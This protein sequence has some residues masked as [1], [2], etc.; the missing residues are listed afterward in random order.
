MLL[1]LLNPLADC[2]SLVI[3]FKARLAH[4]CFVIAMCVC[5]G[6][7]LLLVF[8]ALRY[9]LRFCCCLLISYLFC[10]LALLFVCVACLFFL[11]CLRV[12][13]LCCMLVLFMLLVGCLCCLLDFCLCNLI[14]CCLCLIVLL[15]VI[16]LF[17]VYRVC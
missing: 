9:L 5:Y 14:L 17:V 7:G 11:S 8:C 15:Y 12:C 1:R 2:H 6:F 3:Y 13:C 10:W 16:Y 4:P